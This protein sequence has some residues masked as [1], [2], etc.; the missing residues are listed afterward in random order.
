MSVPVSY[1]QLEKVGK[2]V[3]EKGVVLHP[4]IPLF[5]TAMNVGLREEMAGGRRITRNVLHGWAPS[6]F[7]SRSAGQVEEIY[8]KVFFCEIRNCTFQGGVS[9]LQGNA[10]DWLEDH[11]EISA[12]P[13]KLTSFGFYDHVRLAVLMKGRR[14]RIQVLDWGVL[15]RDL[16]GNQIAAVSRTLA[17]R[18][19]IGASRARSREV[20]IATV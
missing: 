19:K 13:S 1:D 4:R 14:V 2:A 6:L 20:E 8:K 9:A 15:A 7:P 5:L 18:A 10:V 11:F 12:D 17:D 3:A 16:Q